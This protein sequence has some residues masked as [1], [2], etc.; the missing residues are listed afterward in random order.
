VSCPRF[1]IPLLVALLVSCASHS[2]TD[3]SDESAGHKP[4][5]Q[6]LGEKN[7]YK[8]D[9]KGNWVPQN[10]KRSSFESQ[11]KSPYFQGDYQKKTYQAQTYTKNILVG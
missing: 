3:D 4:L 2:G 9:A 6:R 1:I 5:S 11:G 8:Q 10:D 7:G